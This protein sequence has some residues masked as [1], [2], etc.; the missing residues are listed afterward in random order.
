MDHQK[1][2]PTVELPVFLFAA[3][4]EAVG[5][6]QVTIR[7]PLPTTALALRKILSQLDPQLDRWLAVS[8]LAI[9]RRFVADED[10]IDSA[11]EIAVIPPVSGG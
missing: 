8:R 10:P 1:P 9:D 11:T 4:R 5:S 3:V 7:T 6:D 2:N